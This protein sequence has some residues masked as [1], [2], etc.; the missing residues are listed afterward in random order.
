[1]VLTIENVS[2]AFDG[3]QAVREVTFA[4]APQSIVALVGP[5]GAGKT[6]LFNLV[7]GFLAPDAGGLSFA[8]SSLTGKPPHRVANL[9]IGRTFQ[10]LRLITRL[11]TLENV[12][13]ACKGQAGE[14]FWE[15][16][17]GR[18]RHLEAS[19]S[20]RALGLLEFVGL[21]GAASQLAGE[22]SYG[23]QKLLT[24]ACCLAGN[25]SLL[26]LDEP[27]AGVQ[28]E[29]VAK[30]T[31]LLESLREQGKTVLF[32]EHNL[33]AVMEVADRVIVMDEG[34]VIA[35]GEPKAVMENPA[36]VESYLT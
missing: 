12:M 9:G 34:K 19:N 18:W 20:L 3:V 32:I 11:T 14:G 13:L 2:K 5:N 15:A 26:L 21:S 22:L 35:D 7:S 36:V 23:Q 8:G 27:V 33:T 24:L 25:A 10:N 6:T 17:F 31:G 16:A 4:V 30:I 29:M 28:P 1:M